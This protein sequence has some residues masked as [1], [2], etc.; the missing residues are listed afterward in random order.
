LWSLYERAKSQPGWRTALFRASQTGVLPEVELEAARTA[1][2]PAEYAQEFECSFD[3]AIP[4]AYYGELIAAA[5]AAGQIG[6]VPHDPLLTVDTAWDLGVGDATAI[7]FCQRVGREVRLIDYHESSGMGLAHYAELL[8]G[9]GYRYGEHI[10]PH[11]ARAR[12]MGSGKSR[13]ETLTALGFRPRV[14][15]PAEVADG[16]EAVRQLIPRCWFDAGKCAR[17]LEALRHYRAEW[18]ERAQA[19][20]AKPRHDWASHG[21]DALRYLAMGLREETG[22]P[23]AIDYDDR[24]V[25]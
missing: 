18:D 14:L 3:A 12:E 22:A 24:G 13:V 11:D 1:M 23:P 19:L 5:E 21:A 9:K 8:R 15:A 20:K 16:R 4:G 25:V 2:S 17:G 7:W 10:L 6:A